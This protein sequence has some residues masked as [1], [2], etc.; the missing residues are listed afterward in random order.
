MARRD[1]GIRLRHMLDH[2]REAIA[3]VEGRSRADLDRDRLLELGLVRLIEIIGEAA[4]RVTIEFRSAHSTVPWP[5]VVAM[6]N[7]VVHGY[8]EVDLDVLWDTVREDLPPLVTVL[9]E[10]VET[11]GG[12]EAE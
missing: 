1:D 6:R 9:D 12:G 8:D 5:A 4:A 11:D 10:L 2:A 7:R 3:I